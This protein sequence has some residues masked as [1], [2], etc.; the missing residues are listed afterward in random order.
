MILSKELSEFTHNDQDVYAFT[1]QNSNGLS[2]RI[3]N[4]GATLLSVRMP[5]RK[6]TIGEIT[7][8]FDSIGDYIDRIRASGDSPDPYFGATIGRYA[9]RISQG[10]CIIENKQYNLTCNENNINH[11]HGGTNGFDKVIWNFQIFEM[12]KKAG[13]IF[14]YH[15]HNGEEGYPGNLEARA[16]YSLSEN[17]LLL[18]DFWAKTDQ[19]T[20]VNLANHA[21]WNLADAGR[22]TILE[23]ELLLNC[24]KYLPSDNN[25]IPNGDLQD[26]CGSPMDFIKPKRIGKDIRDV[27][28]GYDHCF[29]ING[30]KERLNFAARVH[31]PAS[32][33]CM[34]ISTT[35][36]GIQFYSGNFLEGVLCRNST[37]TKKHN[38]FVL[39][40]EY[41]PN[42]VNQ[43]NFESPILYPRSTYH[44]Y[45]IHRFFIT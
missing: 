44:H 19:P 34:E 43:Q 3:M 12:E 23:H 22:G 6:G 20:P 17:N 45:T 16:V 25:L 30:A 13:V 11:L 40:T 21:C 15:S 35:K 31:E 4:Y 38:G 42:S 24:K 2:I 8:G 26:V 1:V 9:N 36:P 37:R 27:P 29:V 39:L 7:L 32:G 41:F 5:D 18:F 10:R 14:S 28:D 33:R